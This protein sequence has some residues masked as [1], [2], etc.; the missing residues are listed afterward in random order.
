MRFTIIK[1]ITVQW[2]GIYKVVQLSHLRFQS[3]VVTPER[4]SDTC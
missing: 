1:Y 4:N 2:F 3:I